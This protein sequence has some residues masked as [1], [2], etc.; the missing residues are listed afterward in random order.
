MTRVCAIY[1]SESGNSERRLKTLAKAWPDAKGVEFSKADIMSGDDAA[2]KGLEALASTYDVIVIAASSYGDGDAPDN[3]VK[4]LT[5]LYQAE[6]APL[7]G[8]Q[9][10]VLGFGSTDYETFQNNP[11]LTDKLM[12]ELGSRRMLERVEIDENETLA[13]DAALAKFAKNVVAAFADAAATKT[14]KDVC[15][16]DQPADVILD[17]KDELLAGGGASSSPLP[18]LVVALVGA[19]AAYYYSTLE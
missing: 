11:R 4:F 17:K 13:G 6:G 18:L 15:G 2:S 14:A 19:A 1:G 10:C 3:F 9:H 7:K 5:A 12:G 16:W 8:C